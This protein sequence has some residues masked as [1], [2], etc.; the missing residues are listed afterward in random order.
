M[1]IYEDNK[2]PDF[3]WD[4]SSILPQ[5]G[6]LR[7]AQG[8]LLGMISDLGFP[9]EEEAE[10]HVLTE[11]ILASSKIEGAA[12][13]AAKVRSSVSKQ[14]GLDT[15]SLLSD[16]DDVDGFVDIMFDATKNYAGE[17]THERLFSWHAALFPT[18]HSGL[19]RIDV[20]HYRSNEMRV[21]SGAFGKEVTHYRAPDP[22]EVPSMMERFIAW[23]NES[24]SE[25]LLKAGIAHLWFLTIHP[26]DDGNGRIARALT[27]LLLA[28]SDKS[29]RR[30]YS[31]AGQI[32]N[33]RE[34]YYTILERTQKG[35][36]D[37][38]SWLNWFFVMLNAAIEQSEQ[39]IGLVLERAAFWKKLNGVALNERQHTVLKRLQNGFEGKLTA[40]K[41][42]KLC[43]TSPDTALRDINDLI[44]K[45]ILIKDAQGGR[46]TS[47]SLAEAFVKP[48]EL[49]E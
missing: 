17:L 30:Y 42:A 40:R 37:I 11:E 35:S 15:P 48:G 21:V 9:F 12:L 7:F 13:D 45:G 47:Y 4:E 10:L 2:W 33:H 34:E 6:R 39:G 5:I 31:M 43:K 44:S 16:T 3:Q 1:Y 22:E 29:P 49:G 26:F 32:L 27:E 28:R 25:P 36:C 19:R 18:G 24:K 41:W 46:S 23:F 14:L 20:A 8:H 38:T